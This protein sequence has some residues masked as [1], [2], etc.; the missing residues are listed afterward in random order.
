M[1]TDGRSTIEIW[2]FAFAL[3]QHFVLDSDWEHEILKCR[4]FGK[5]CKLNFNYITSTSL[6]EFKSTVLFG[7]WCFIDHRTIS[8][9][10]NTIGRMDFR[11]FIQIWICFQRQ[12]KHFPWMLFE[13]VRKFALCWWTRTA[14]MYGGEKLLCEDS[15]IWHFHNTQRFFDSSKALNVLIPNSASIWRSVHRSRIKLCTR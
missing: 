15:I 14:W 6:I 13:S 11:Q 5:Y 2:P 3:S 4:K 1:H 9:R 7:N 8:N 12:W 10:T